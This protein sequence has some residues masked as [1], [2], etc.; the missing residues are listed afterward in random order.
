M[1]LLKH[2]FTSFITTLFLLLIGQGV[3]GQVSMSS[4]GSHSHNFNSLATSG[5]SITWTDN[6]TISNWYSQRTGTGTTYNAGDGTANSGILYSYGTG[7]NSDR[8]LGTIG[9]SNAAAGSFAHGVLLRNISGSTITDIKVSYTL[10]QWRKSS[11]TESQSITF[12]YKTSSSSFTA[13]N[14][15]SNGTWTEV[16]GLSLSSPI[17]T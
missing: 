10:E 11:V 13:L 4:T 9:S 7:T 14:P 3:W 12:Y 8:A 16:A 15:N 17:N 2:Y 1:K 6:S 5:S